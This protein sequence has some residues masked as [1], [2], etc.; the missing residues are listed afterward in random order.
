MNV[1]TNGELL[2]KKFTHVKLKILNLCT[3]NDFLLDRIKDAF[4]MEILFDMKLIF[5]LHVD[6]LLKKLVAEFTSFF[7]SLRFLR[8]SINLSFFIER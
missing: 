5:N 1:F 4:D 8:M 7:A 2:T 6:A 3:L